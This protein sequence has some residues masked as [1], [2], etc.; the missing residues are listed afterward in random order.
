[1]S[2]STRILALVLCSAPLAAQDVSTYER[3]DDGWLRHENG[4]TYRVDSGVITA[5]FATP[6]EDVIGFLAA[7]DGDAAGLTVVR[8]NRL[9]ATDLALAPGADPLAAVA[10]LRATGA[11]VW[12]EENT[13]GEYTVTPNDPNYS[14]QWN[15]NNSGQTGGT[16]DAD[17][18]APE[19]WE[20]EDGD[21]SVI[22]AVLDSG[23]DHT[24]PDLN[25]N[26]WD[27]A[28]E[29]LNGVDDDGNGFVDDVMG[30]D[31]DGNDNDPNGSFF[32]GTAV[33]SVIGAVGNNGS[34]ITGLAG[35]A[36][37]GQ[38]VSIMPCNV[39]SF[40][41]IGSVLDDAIIYA[42][43]NGARVIT[44]SLTVASSQAIDDACQY[45]W[46]T[47][48]VFVDNAAGTSFGG[49][50]GYPGSLPTVM[51]VASTDH[52]D[53][54]SSFGSIGPEV[55][56]SAPGTAVLMLN[57]GGGTTVSDGTSFASPH[58]AALAGLMF[59]ANPGLTNNDVR[60]FIRSTADDVATPGYDT[61]T[62]DGRINAA[63]AVAAVAGGFTP[64]EVLP[65]GVGVAGGS[66]DVPV[67]GTLGGDAPSNGDADF[68]VTLRRAAPDA[69]AWLVVGFD[70]A[71]IPFK[72][73]T[74]LV[75]VVNPFILHAVT[76]SGT[77]GAVDAL[78][79]PRDDDLIG[80]SAYTQWFVDDAGAAAN[81]AMSVA[82]ELVIGS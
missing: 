39:G 45:A 70:S 57:L 36:S 77:G 10:A 9:G 12:A 16:A 34:F 42:A 30:W 31:F 75:D 78:P 33:A 17:V 24:H 22:V 74:L 81:L 29:V 11:V 4:Y 60:S 67:I 64:G 73:G 50:V 32:H 41:P 59:S 38:G 26:I 62:G 72:G 40:S 82:L 25:G 19:A 1:V 51:A 68:A 71:S 80:L 13:L 2:I 21:P 63:A 79:I 53:L 37:D 61:G 27:N 35:G 47:V 69:S 48:G 28:G 66:G 54:R 49:S 15:L 43:D 8:T 5:R 23:T 7:L 6:V 18:D 58:V 14:S 65:Y 44:M 76:T 20:I 56:V 3:G 46:D 55:E 52:N